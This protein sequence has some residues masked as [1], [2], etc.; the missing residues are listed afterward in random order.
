MSLMRYLCFFLIVLAQGQVIPASHPSSMHPHAM[1]RPPSAGI[2]G[3]SQQMIVHTTSQAAP[4]TSSLSQAHYMSSQ[5]VQ[6]QLHPQMSHPQHHSIHPQLNVPTHAQACSAPL[7]L[8]S[9]LNQQQ[10]PSQQ[11][12]NPQEYQEDLNDLELILSGS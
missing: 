6:H 10:V 5:N 1:P 4:Q 2:H 7:G 12:M 9:Q 3:Q 8:P 11:T